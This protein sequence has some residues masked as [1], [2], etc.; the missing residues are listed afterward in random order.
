MT[1]IGALLLYFLQQIIHRLLK[2]R[3]EISLYYKHVHDLINEEPASF[4]EN[5]NILTM[6]LWIEI[7][8]NK[9]V[10]QVVRNVNLSLY[11][12]GVLIDKATQVNRVEKGE[13]KIYLGNNGS[14]SFNLPAESI[15][16]F[17]VYY[18][19]NKTKENQEF[20]SV[21]LTYYTFKSKIVSTKILDISQ[22][23]QTKSLSLN[24]DWIE[25]N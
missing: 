5:Y 7:H 23:W 8:N 9:E 4:K 19:F 20:D 17:E 3:G 1:L 18:L 21:Y 13:D 22:G 24:K 11:K 2:R 14:Y 25:G 10:N 12:S 16:Q 15:H 6:P